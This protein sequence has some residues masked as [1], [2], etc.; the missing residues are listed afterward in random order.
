M[1]IARCPKCDIPLTDAEAAVGKCPICSSNIS[2][3]TVRV[4]GN[5]APPTTRRQAPAVERKNLSFL[6][7][8][9]ILCA[10][11]VVFAVVQAALMGF[12]SGAGSYGAGAGVFATYCVLLAM[13]K[14][15]NKKTS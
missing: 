1:A 14:V 9:G 5:E 12:R 13:G 10:G 6:P 7:L 11:G 3:P 2:V 4:R 15:G 8:F